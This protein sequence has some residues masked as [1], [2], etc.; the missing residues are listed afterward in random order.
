MITLKNINK[1]YGT[2]VIFSDFNFTAC[3][4]EFVGIVGPSGSGKTSLL[5][6]LT[7]L[8]KN[9]EGEVLY[10]N[11]SLDSDNKITKFYKNDLGYLL[12]N[13]GLVDNM[14]IKENID[15]YVDSYDENELIKSLEY[16]GINAN[17]K[18][19]IYNLSGGEQQRIALIRVLL[20]KPK[21]ILADEPTGNLDQD[22]KNL[23]F[24]ELKKISKTGTT[25]I[26]VSHDLE[27]KNYAD[28]VVEL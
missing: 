18:E 27:I 13:F 24:E 26:V 3:G 4:G 21:I 11:V 12:Q 23:I 10:N 19:K 1:K 20:K 17:I 28:K 5:N 14:T 6:I 16:F 9:H 22:N 7:R 2:R 15:L 25:V 8:D